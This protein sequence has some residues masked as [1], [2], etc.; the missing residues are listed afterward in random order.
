MVWLCLPVGLERDDFSQHRALEILE[1]SC[2]LRFVRGA[3]FGRKPHAVREEP[4]ILKHL[5]DGEMAHGSLSERSSR[6]TRANRKLHR[7][8]ACAC[9]PAA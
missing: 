6:V 8:P 1:C 3:D 7:H 9:L 2:L 5:A 4:R